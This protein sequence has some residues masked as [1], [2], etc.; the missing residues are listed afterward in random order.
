MDNSLDNP[1]AGR[2]NGL[3]THFGKLLKGLRE[4]RGL[5]QE[6]LGK[7]AGLAAFSIRRAEAQAACIFRRSNALKVFQALQSAPPPMADEEASVFLRLAG[8]DQGLKAVQP[9]AD[10]T[11]ATAAAS[12]PAAKEVIEARND[13]DRWSAHIFLEDLMAERGAKNILTALESLAAAWSI[14]LPPRLSGD[15]AKRA[16]GLMLI[17]ETESDGWNIRTHAPVAT[18]PPKP[19]RPKASVKRRAQ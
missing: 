4:S 18:T 14:D 6:A 17:A 7:A 12:M 11:R 9:S 10:A 19:T 16:T 3:V 13:P 1:A 5:S 2:W 8:L 15:A